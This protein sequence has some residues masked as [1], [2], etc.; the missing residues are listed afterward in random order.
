MSVE[1]VAIAVAALLSALSE[2]A[3]GA[4]ARNRFG[5]GGETDQTGAGRS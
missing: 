1:L 4:L 2:A 5:E 3:L